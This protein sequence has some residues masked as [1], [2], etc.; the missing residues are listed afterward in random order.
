MDSEDVEKLLRDNRYRNQFETGTSRGAFVPGR[1]ML[2][3]EMAFG[4]PADVSGRFRPIYGYCTGSDEQAP[5]VIQYGDAVLCLRSEVRARTTYTFGDSLDEIALLSPHPPFAPCPLSRPGTLALDARRDIE[6][7]T[8]L[9]NAT[10]YGYIESQTFGDVR[11]K[12]VEEIVFTL[13][14]Q[15][16]DGVRKLLT[17]SGMKWRIVEGD[18]P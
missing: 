15:P 4:V 9:S 14:A 11:P 7:A 17:R 10:G 12:D 13:G 3:E 16:T 5:S 18:I 2:V 8:R 6:A 1:R